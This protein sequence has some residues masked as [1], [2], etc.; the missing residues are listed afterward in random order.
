M[1]T[2][3]QRAR[4]RAQA[5]TLETVLIVGKD[6]VTP[7]VAS[8]AREVLKARELVKGRVL[9]SAPLS[10]REVC[11]ILA[12]RCR[13]EPVQCIGSRF[14]LYKRNETAPQIAL[15]GATRAAPRAPQ[16]ERGGNAAQKAQFAHGAKARGG[17]DALWGHGAKAGRGGGAPHGR[18]AQ[19]RRD[20]DALWGH[21]AKA[22][23]GG[24]A[25]HGRGAQAKRGGD[26]PGGRGAQTK[27]SAGRS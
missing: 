25:P 11:G 27:R 3:K 2:S 5:N 13:A 15:T 4:L 14:V 7:S 16:P 24:D 20:G 10:A 21:G 23:R 18:G 8:Q 9:E 19:P 17:G 1:L 22:M 12:E 26:A 6:G